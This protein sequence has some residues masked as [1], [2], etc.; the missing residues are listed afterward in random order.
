MKVQS[1]LLLA[2]TIIM[3]GCNTKSVI[4]KQGGEW[5]WDN[6]NIQDAMSKKLKDIEKEVLAKVE[7]IQ[8]KNDS[9][10]NTYYCEL[11]LQEDSYVLMCIT[12]SALGSDTLDYLKKFKLNN[13]L[14]YAKTGIVP[15]IKKRLQLI[16]LTKDYQPK[17][18]LESRIIE[19][20]REYPGQATSYWPTEKYYRDYDYYHDKHFHNFKLHEYKIGPLAEGKY[21]YVKIFEENGVVDV[22]CVSD[23]EKGRTKTIFIYGL[24]YKYPVAQNTV[25][26]VNNSIK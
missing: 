22:L 24:D 9:N 3:T 16:V 26:E 17:N 23:K 25:E 21:I 19:R 12:S 11:M 1:F 15:F 2:F 10:T 4:T 13:E 8:Q 7:E 14:K 5:L 20:I 18:E 6:Q